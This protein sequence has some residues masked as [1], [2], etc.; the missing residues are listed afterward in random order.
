MGQNTEAGE[1][2]SC[3]GAGATEAL[4]NLL[5]YEGK[6]LLFDDSEVRLFEEQDFLQACSPETSSSSTPYLLF[7]RRMPEP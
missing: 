1:E 4:H 3:G 2:T 6:W 5:D 7:Y